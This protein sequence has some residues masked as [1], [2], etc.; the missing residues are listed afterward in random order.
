MKNKHLTIFA[1]AL[2]AI[3]SILG[4]K[5]SP[6][7]EKTEVS[8]KFI[9]IAI[10]DQSKLDQVPKTTNN[11]EAKSILGPNIIELDCKKDEK[12]LI[13]KID[14]PFE[15]ISYYGLSHWSGENK[16]H[17][18]TGGS[19]NI[20]G[21]KAD[22]E[23][24][25]M[26]IF[27]EDGKDVFESQAKLVAYQKPVALAY[28]IGKIYEI[29]D[30]LYLSLDTHFFEDSG[31]SNLTIEE[32]SINNDMDGKE[33]IDR[34]IYTFEGR[35]FEAEDEVLMVEYDVSMKEISRQSHKAKDIKEIKVSSKAKFLAVKQGQ[36]IEIY[37]R[38]SNNYTF[39][40]LIDDGTDIYQAK[41]LDINWQ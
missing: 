41:R 7:N 10:W 36:K 35:V 33:S 11:R 30:S 26:N 40:A 17:T 29:N 27:K 6:S 15:V 24:P 1:I 5:L 14:F 38:D 8:Q 28:E 9:G 13:E 18:P 21:G 22:I 32:S 37:S 4:M 3:L 34:G 31:S 39:L 20:G 19:R 2:V 25:K 16:D 23:D 12:G